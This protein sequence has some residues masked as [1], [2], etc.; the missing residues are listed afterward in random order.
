MSDERDLREAIAFERFWDAM[1]S[2]RAEQPQSDLEPAAIAA[3]KRL[4]AMGDGPT[5]DPSRAT[6]IWE[7]IMHAT[8]TLP[9]TSSTPA[10]PFSANSRHQPR[11]IVR[12]PIRSRVAPRDYAHAFS[13]AILAAVLI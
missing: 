3:A 10:E 4:H 1:V 7:E 9:R 13:A 5:V 8:A 11:L 2:G 12:G 6:S